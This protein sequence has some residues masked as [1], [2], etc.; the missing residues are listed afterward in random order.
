M[1]TTSMAVEFKKVVIFRFL[2]FM[3]NDVQGAIATLE[4][5]EGR[6]PEALFG[7]IVAMR[8]PDGYLISLLPPI[9]VSK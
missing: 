8:T 6:V 5:M 9:R 4:L 7:K 1:D 3:A 2:V